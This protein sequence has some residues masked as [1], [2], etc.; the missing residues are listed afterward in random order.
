MKRLLLFI[1]WTDWRYFIPPFTEVTTSDVVHNK[2]LLAESGINFPIGTS[3]HMRHQ[4]RSAVQFFC[5]WALS[6]CVYVYVWACSGARTE[7]WLGCCCCLAVSSMQAKPG[8]LHWSR[9]HSTA[10]GRPPWRG[11]ITCHPPNTLSACTLLSIA[12]SVSHI[13]PCPKQHFYSFF[14]KKLAKIVTSFWRII[15]DMVELKWT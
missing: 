13:L 3:H 10:T 9:W 11:D 4:Y 7:C 2:R 8:S 15:L 1:S 14:C 12:S 6:M 5:G